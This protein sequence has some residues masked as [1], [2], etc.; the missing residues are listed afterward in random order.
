MD[1]YIFQFTQSFAR[2]STILNTKLFKKTTLVNVSGS[3]QNSFET[4][5]TANIDKFFDFFPTNARYVKNVV[6]VFTAKIV[7]EIK[8]SFSK[9]K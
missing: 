6:S 4:S 9:S 3:T 7:T 5:L 8:E 1:H 2:R